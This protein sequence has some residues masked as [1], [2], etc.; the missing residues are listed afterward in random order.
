MDFNQFSPQIGTVPASGELPSFGGGNSLGPSSHEKGFSNVLQAVSHRVEA[1][2]EVKSR[3][4][5]AKTEDR[6]AT[7][8]SEGQCGQ[9]RRT[10]GSRGAKQ[11]ASQSENDN[12][13]T[14]TTPSV[15]RRPS[16][17]ASDG[18][19]SDPRAPQSETADQ[20]SATTSNISTAPAQETSSSTNTDAHA[21]QSETGNDPSSTTS[22][23]DPLLISLVGATM[24]TPSSPVDSTHDVAGSGIL[25]SDVAGGS[26]LP[27]APMVQP[28]APSAEGVARPAASANR[29]EDLA[30][31]HTTPATEDRVAT[32]SLPTVEAK[33]D[34]ERTDSDIPVTVQ[35]DNGLPLTA[36]QG[37]KVETMDPNQGLLIKE[38]QERDVPQ[39]P[40][41]SG[42][43]AV[44]GQEVAKQAATATT[45][46]IL[47]QHEAVAAERDQV[48]VQP[49]LGKGELSLHQ[50]HIQAAS[51]EAQ[52]AAVLPGRMQDDGQGFASGSDGKGK[53][54]GL[55]WLAH[56]DFQSA[57]MPS[58]APEPATV[59]SADGGHQYSSY[60]QGQG[61]VPSNIRPA[62]TSTAPAPPQP[63]PLGPDPEPTAVPRTHAVQFDMAPA[64]FGQLRV[65]VV[66]SDHTIHTHLS[67][68]RA[69]LGQMLTGQ[70]E[71]LS[72]QLTAAGLDLGRFQVQ[73]DQERSH[74][75][76]Q[77]RQSQ[78][79]SGTTQQQR[80]PRQQDRPQDVPAPPQKRSGVLSLFA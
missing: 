3:T 8:E 29:P 73:V 6:S 50:K 60:Q 27:Q 28:A 47:Q 70:Q 56:A 77:D 62:A 11:R 17:K 75:S 35:A 43:V 67:T 4:A 44:Q 23:A 2:Q 36:P 65:R 20:P 18:T 39:A 58:R 1:R 25:T 59:E 14:R 5:Q 38:H 46:P 48:P 37:Q 71:Q 76:G 41:P 40:V 52:P 79:H 10:D 31:Q 13:A 72:A 55:K 12:R 34:S 64:D 78:A 26:G 57:E 45:Q 22:T 32:V 19:E 61:G 68:D 74:Q 30:D 16:H 42:Q 66:L 63:S 80:D 54:D 53:D 9:S 24:V 69:E 33:S 7:P 21:S 51:S 15:S 49:L